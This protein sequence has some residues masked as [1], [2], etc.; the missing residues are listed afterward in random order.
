MC[1]H[2]YAVVVYVL[3]YGCAAAAS[4]FLFKRSMSEYVSECVCA[5]F[6]NTH[7][8]ILSFAYFMCT[9]AASNYL[10]TLHMMMIEIY[11]SS[12][13]CIYTYTTSIYESIYIYTVIHTISCL[14]IR[15]WCFQCLSV[16]WLLVRRR[17]AA[18]AVHKR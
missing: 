2:V 13:T 4:D 16:C 8:H 1:I 6:E 18:A 15:A 11:C 3:R 14:Y 5:R 17:A 12:Q 10:P 7:T 9:V